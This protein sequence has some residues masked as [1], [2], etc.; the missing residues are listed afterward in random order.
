VK[1]RTLAARSKAQRARQA[2]AHVSAVP[3]QHPMLRLQEVVGNQQVTQLLRSVVLS[4]QAVLAPDAP[5]AADAA[6]K[7]LAPAQVSAA[8]SFYKNQPSR[9]TPSI[10]SEIQ[11]QVGAEPTG[12]ADEDTAQ[13]V[14]VFQEK[15]PPLKVDGMAGPRTLPTAFPFGLRTKKS[16][17]AFI[18]KAKVVQTEW[19]K[20]ATADE[21][22]KALIAAVNEQLVAAGVPPVK[23]EFQNVPGEFGHFS[24]ETWT[25]TLGEPE[26][27][28]DDA[29]EKER[30]EAST[31]VYHEARHAEQWFMMARLLAGEGLSAKAIS[32]RM[33]IPEDDIAKKAKDKP[34]AKGSMDALIAQGWFDSVY[35]VNAAK[36]NATLAKH[37]ELAKQQEAKQKVLDQKK[38][39][40]KKKTEALAKAQAEVALNPS[41]ANV[42][43]EQ[44]A[45][46]ALDRA[47]R[48]E[49]AAQRDFDSAN[50]RLGKASEAV[51]DL[52]EEVDATMT[53]KPVQAQATPTVPKPSP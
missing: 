12:E 44:E 48:A 2:P 50:E 1:R 9:Y 40:V 8:I 34:L 43:K 11:K 39:D 19:V 52:P 29:S 7:P 36:R 24:F 22:A 53:E 31:T 15:N 30:R 16:T 18:T 10:M 49:T 37:T 28:K 27:A 41:A 25:M 23:R 32:K 3:E 51:L 13:K 42:K 45:R 38:E 5:G 17:D 20:L 26:F 35:G 21:R 46:A 6:K 14:A 33:G 47:Q 4:R